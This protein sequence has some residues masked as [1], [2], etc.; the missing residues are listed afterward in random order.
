MADR[1]A[2]VDQRPLV[3]EVNRQMELGTEMRARL[4]RFSTRFARRYGQLRR[5]P[6]RHA[7]RYLMALAIGNS[8]PQRFSV[9]GFDILMRPGT[10]DLEVACESLGGELEPAISYLPSDFS[11]VI[12]DAGGYIGTSALKLAKAFPKATVFVLEPSE[13]NFAVLE[14]NVRALSNITPVKAALSAQSGSEVMRD[15][16]T[17][18]WGFTIVADP[19][20]TSETYE[21]NSTKTYS[22]NAFLEK[23][24]IKDVGI[25]KVDIEGGEAALLSRP[26]P[27][28]SQT[29]LLVIELHEWIVPGVARAFEE[30]TRGRGNLK[31]PGE[32]YLSI[33]KAASDV[34]A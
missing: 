5:M 20:D 30:A 6:Y 19:A 10:T 25:F 9:L 29:D 15:R 24:D 8:A 2:A 28:L 22:I 7:L 26:Q 13:A 3:G 21:L 17:G 16:G 11:G 23:M 31:L 32:K 27:W 14:E 33:R 1:K 12:I 18:P 34:L 4:Q